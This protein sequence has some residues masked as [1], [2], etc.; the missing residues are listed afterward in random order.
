VVTDN[1]N[2]EGGLQSAF[3][4]GFREYEG[5]ICYPS[6]NDDSLSTFLGECTRLI[7]SDSATE[8]KLTLPSHTLLTPL[9][10][11]EKNLVLKESAFLGFRSGEI[12]SAEFFFK[13]Q[14]RLRFGR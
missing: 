1:G 9:S 2:K 3:V 5:P 10:D 13:K 7:L 6:V 14:K 11:G 12:S 4:G 8:N